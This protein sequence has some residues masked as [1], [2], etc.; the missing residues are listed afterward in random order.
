MKVLSKRILIILVLL[1]PFQD[2]VNSF[3]FKIGLPYGMIFFLGVMKEI[4]IFLLGLIFI[5]H[6]KGKIPKGLVAIYL[7]ILYVFVL[8]LLHDLP[9][10]VKLAGLR[11]YLILFISLVAGYFIGLE[12]WRKICQSKAFVLVAALFVVFCFLQYFILPLS[13]FKDLFPILD[14]KR[15]ALNL[16]TSNE[17]YD[18]GLP[19]NYMGEAGERMLGPFNEPLY[20]AYF[21]LPFFNYNLWAYLETK[22]ND[23]LLIALL[24]FLIIMLSQTRAVILMAIFYFLFCFKSMFNIKLLLYAIVGVVLVLLFKHE[25][26]MSLVESLLTTEGRS[27][28]HFLAYVIGIQ[29]ILSNLWGTGLGSGSAITTFLSG[30]NAVSLSVENAF[31]NMSLDLGVIITLSFLITLIFGFYSG[32]KNRNKIIHKTPSPYNILI[33]Q[34]VLMGFLAPHIFT[35]RVIIPYMFIIGL[36][37]K[38]SYNEGL[39]NNYINDK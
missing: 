21:A 19:V 5:I 16:E 33:L 2:L 14:M 35:I 7:I 36:A 30:N 28:D 32:E 27:A 13:I 18:T 29:L 3:L 17:H 8:F 31:I 34:F 22:K 11:Q 15:E 10:D 1:I 26:I 38:E 23:K 37:F 25:W 20:T 6:N 39:H 12:H 9:F 4:M 24:F